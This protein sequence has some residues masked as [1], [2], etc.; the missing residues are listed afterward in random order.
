MIM[1]IYFGAIRGQNNYA[2]AKG[3]SIY[4]T[5]L[6]LKL[7]HQSTKLRVIK[8]LLIQNWIDFKLNWT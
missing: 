1:E 7:F 3:D 8:V 2:S 6:Y 5:I 4:K